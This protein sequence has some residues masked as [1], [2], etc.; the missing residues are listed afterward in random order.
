MPGWRAFDLAH[1]A[2][3]YEPA[4]DEVSPDA[5]ALLGRPPHSLEHFLADHGEAFRAS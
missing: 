5:A 1:I 2:R 4:D 3:A